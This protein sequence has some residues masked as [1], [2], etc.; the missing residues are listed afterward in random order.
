MGNKVLV[1]E[2][3]LKRGMSGQGGWNAKQFAILGIDWPPRK[4]WKYG[5]VNRLWL[6]P[7]DAETFL[8]LRPVTQPTFP[9]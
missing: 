4:G 6:T 1:T 3:F 7:E 5:I 2:D 8:A 9:W